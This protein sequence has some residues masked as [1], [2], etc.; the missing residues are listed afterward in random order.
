MPDH[1]IADFLPLVLQHAPSAPIP[2]AAEHLR[3]AAIDFCVQTRCWRYRASVA[4][5]ANPVTIPV[6]LNAVVH[7]I[8]RAEFDGIALEPALPGDFTDAELSAVADDNN[9]PTWMTQEV[10]DTLIVLPPK[11]GTLTLNLFLK[12]PAGVVF[13]QDSTRSL[14]P[15]FMFDHHAA[16][17]A[18]GALASLLTLPDEAIMDA[19]RASHF[20]ALFQARIDAMR[21]DFRR[22]Q[23]RRM[24]RQTR[25][26]WM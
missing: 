4:F 21:S 19:G 12:P 24:P 20:A 8:E 17:L 9:T 23:Q 13:G 11:A 3:Q 25:S 2:L 5:T 22:G 10:P 26:P 16:F 7:E 14:L 6:P 18:Y 15:Q 1:S